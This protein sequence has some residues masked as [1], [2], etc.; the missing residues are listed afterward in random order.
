M[1]NNVTE[2]TNKAIDLLKTLDLEELMTVF[3]TVG[4]VISLSNPETLV[5][6]LSNAIFISLYSDESIGVDH[7]AQVLKASVLAA[8][9]KIGMQE[10]MNRSA[11]QQGQMEN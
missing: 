1:D 11:N 6:I 7:F 4:E 10:L 8:N 5:S 2:K 9:D 3:L